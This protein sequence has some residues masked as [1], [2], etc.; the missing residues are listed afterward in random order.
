MRNSFLPFS[1]PS[2][3]ERDINAVNDVLRSGWITT[4]QNAAKFEEEFSKYT[5]APAS[6]ALA[7]ATGGMHILMKALDIGEGD[8]VI[9]L[10]IIRKGEAKNNRLLVVMANGYGK[11]TPLKEYK[12]Q[13]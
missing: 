1:K 7:S 10:D 5:G 12:V 13:R 9:T 4:G 8:E 2:I 6:V 11:Q 3:D